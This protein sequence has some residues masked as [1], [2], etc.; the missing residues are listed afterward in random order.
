MQIKT[1]DDATIE[2]VW[3]KGSIVSG[4]NSSEV[5]KDACGAT[6]WREKYGNRNSSYGWEIDHIKPVSDNGSDSLT[7]LQPLHWEN[8][9]AKGDGSRLVCEITS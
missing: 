7:N 4:Q 5:R 1:F 2:A 9:A 8:N 3:R 6:I